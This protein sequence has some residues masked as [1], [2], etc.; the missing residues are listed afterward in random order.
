M[1]TLATVKHAPDITYADDLQVGD[2]YPLDTY[3]VT[4]S[5]V[6]DYATA[7]DPQSFHIDK[8]IAE[9][10]AYGGLI[11]SGIHT[12][13]IYQRLAVSGVFGGWSVIA[14]KSLTDV[15]FL[16]PVRPDDTLTG[17]IVIEAIDF[18]ERGR[19]LVTTRAELVNQRGERVMTLV[20]EAFV[21]VQP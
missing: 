15:R 6:I 7:W 20:V 2:R 8:E 18:D 1:A 12:L 3:T 9:A 16:R 4:E 19:A 14:G 13:A 11:A 21:R 17:S 10:G 5:E